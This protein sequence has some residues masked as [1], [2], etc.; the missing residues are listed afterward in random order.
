MFHS[1][2]VA[3]CC[4]LGAALVLNGCAIAPN[5]FRIK[6]ADTLHERIL[7]PPGAVDSG[8]TLDLYVE[9]NALQCQTALPT[10]TSKSV[11]V[12]NPYWPAVGSRVI[13]I[14][15]A[16]D[17]LLGESLLPPPAACLNRSVRPAPVPCPQDWI[18]DKFW[19]AIE[20]D[21]DWRKCFPKDALRKLAADVSQVLPH[22]ASESGAL[23]D[24]RTYAR[25]PGPAQR[26]R[27]LAASS[28]PA[29][30]PLD[31]EFV[32][33]L[34]GALVC[35]NREHQLVDP[36]S[37]SSATWVSSENS[38]ARLLD[39]P[40]GHGR[41]VLSRTDTEYTFPVARE[42][43]EKD[44]AKIYE[45]RSWLAVRGALATL[46]PG[47]A[48]LYL[49]YSGKHNVPKTGDWESD[50]SGSLRSYPRRDG[51]PIKPP[52][53]ISPILLVHSQ[54]LKLTPSDLP[55]LEALCTPNTVENDRVERRCFAF[56]DFASVDVLRPFS[57]DGLVHYAP[58][59][60]LTTDV[61]EIAASQR[62]SS[63]RIFRG[64][65]VPMD[66]DVTNARNAVPLAAGDEFGEWR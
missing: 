28:P 22:R 54:P 5:S 13:R 25:E 36:S 46:M 3:R 18:V 7:L 10:R 56:L 21:D 55:D 57:V 63:T 61:P 24:E 37:T 20:E 52:I 47:G 8:Q 30:P 1:S 38:C 9:T 6:S 64:R 43:Y 58:S 65:R 60:T 19:S 34:T 29:I 23:R 62:P 44:E 27:A 35:V 42:F 14:K 31:T 12:S 39:A 66:F 11:T 40:R 2:R 53:P 41:V 26:V 59:G 50:A 16:R 51:E 17:A 15:A 45:A 4:L 48:F 49:Y 33:L 32:S